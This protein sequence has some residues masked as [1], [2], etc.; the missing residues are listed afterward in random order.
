[1][2]FAMKD[3][4]VVELVNAETGRAFQQHT[5]PGGKVFALLEPNDEYFIRV[6]NNCSS[7]KG[8]LVKYEVDGQNLRFC[9]SVKYGNEGI[10]GVRSVKCGTKMKKAL[11]FDETSSTA[12]DSE[13]KMGWVKVHVYEST[14]EGGYRMLDDHEP[15]GACLDTQQKHGVKSSEGCTIL[16][17]KGVEKRKVKAYCRGKK[18][19]TIKMYYGSSIVLVSVGAIPSPPR[20]RL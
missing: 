16:E 2:I 5:G 15:K 6:K 1:M 8:V 11:R 17:V 7:G 13:G 14:N 19:E 4:F 10:G 20:L 9:Q 12:A 3:Q 18:L